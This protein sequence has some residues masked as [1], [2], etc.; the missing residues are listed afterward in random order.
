[1]INKIGLVLF[2]EKRIPK[3]QKISTIALIVGL[4]I[5]IAY[6][7]FTNKIYIVEKE[8]KNSELF[9]NQITKESFLQSLD[10]YKNLS[11]NNFSELKNAFL[12]NFKNVKF[13]EDG[14]LSADITSQRGERQKMLLINFIYE[15]NSGFLSKNLSLIYAFLK[16]FSNKHNYHWLAKDI[17]INL[18]P[19]R[20][21]YNN[22]KQFAEMILSNKDYLKQKL[23][24]TINLD[25]QHDLSELEY[26]ELGINGL[27][28][29]NV[30]MDYYKTFY[31]NL[32][33][34]FALSAN[35][36]VFS[37]GTR[38]YL[39]QILSALGEWLKHFN[40]IFSD[41]GKNLSYA[42]SYIYFLENIICNYFLALGDVN[43]NHLLVSQNLHSI[44][45]KT[46]PK[47]VTEAANPHSVSRYNSSSKDLLGQGFKFIAGIERI[48]KSL[49]KN[50]SD[51]FRGESNYLL[52][53][54]S[55]FANV[56]FI[57]IIL[58]LL[59]LKNFYKYIENGQKLEFSKINGFK[60]TAYLTIALTFSFI[61]FLE[62][63]N[64]DKHTL[65]N[66]NNTFYLIIAGCVCFTSF[67][68]YLLNL[69]GEEYTM[70]NT[71]ISFFIVF[72][73]YNIL[74]LNFG[75][76]ICM[77]A[78]FMPMEAVCLKLEDKR[79]ALRQ[80]L[81]SFGVGYFILMIQP[82]F[83]ENIIVTYI[84]YFNNIYFFLSLVM[85]YLCLRIGLALNKFL[86]NK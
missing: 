56:T 69:N 76:A 44:L 74:F 36:K 79:D 11:I 85:I 22:P 15:N 68:F 29:E 67:I 1:M 8:L 2:D 42:E 43:A 5:V 30:D 46:V 34:N 25:L 78:L 82:V 12:K 28:A 39:T 48:I 40:F 21:F 51:V 62:I 81:L 70:V 45:I 57:L 37:K 50:E 6:P 23:D 77:S 35:R 58:V 64:I 75:F 26:M 10:E 61:L 17:R 14:F 13:E 86:I 20:L 83:I 54:V 80:L 59:T 24:Y 41:D 84:S 33:A 7:Y 19:R 66:Y 60:I 9:F 63:E 31:E 32:G 27:N 38:K 52:S 73:C 16:H 49:S 53:T 18:I 65:N 3:Y 72:N 71:I 4:F 55:T 47:P